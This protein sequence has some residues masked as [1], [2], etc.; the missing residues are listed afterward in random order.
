M[1]RIGIDVGGT[2]T[3]AVLIV[4]EKVVHSVKRPTTADVTSGIL[5]ALRALRAE[6]SAAVKVDAVVIGTTHFIN[7]VVQRRH[8]QKIGAIRIGMPASASLPPFCDWPADLA[9][10]VNG[11]IFMLEGGHD[12]DGRPF[13]PLD[14]AGLKNAARK[15][16][17]EGLRS[18]AVCSSFS[19]LDPSCE[20]TAREILADICPD[21]AVTLSHDLGR[22]GLLE[23][24]NAALLNASLH[25]LAVSTVAAFR[26]A[27][28][29]SGIDAPLFLTQ[30]DGTVMQAEIA[31]AFP[32]MSFASGATNSMRGAAHLSGLDDAMVVD[33][34]GTTSDIGQLRH[35]FPREANAVVEVGGVRTLFRMPDLLSIGLGGGSHV[36]EDPLRVGPLSVSYRLTSDALVFGGSRLTATDI[37]VAA[38]LIDIGDRSRVANLPKRLIEAAL[39]DAWRKLEEDIDRMKTEAGDVPLLA[40]G[41]GAFL[42]PD[43]LPG[44]SEI[45]RVPYGDCANAV[46]AAIAQVSGEADQVFRDLSREDAIAAARDIAADRAVQAGAARDSLK[47]VDVEDMPIAYLPGNALRVRVRVAGAIADPDLPAAA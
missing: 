4:D 25:D 29:D 9:S 11:E 34:G 16:K 32:V 27:I 38:G 43:R 8:V 1:K 14:I 40:V 35:G 18:V 17:D 44:I 24:E 6:P 41:G 33:V 7:A 20:T 36:D 28:A 10:P 12:Y 22:I 13:M 37:A 23:R 15:I 30:N 21:V 46:G 5:D 31:I 2:N 45:V 47:T 42:V 19:P 39:R 3:D 26:K